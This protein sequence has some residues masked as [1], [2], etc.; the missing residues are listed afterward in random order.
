MFASCSG[1]KGGIGKPGGGLN[2]LVNV[3]MTGLVASVEDS[4]LP[5]GPP[6]A[7]TGWYKAMTSGER[8]EYC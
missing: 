1:D 8:S 6:D 2:K 4:K 3:P 5:E 7:A